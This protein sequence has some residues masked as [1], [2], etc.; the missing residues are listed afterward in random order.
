[1]QRTCIVHSRT[2]A[3]SSPMRTGLINFQPEIHVTQDNAAV[4]NHV[5]IASQYAN[6]A[7]FRKYANRVGINLPPL[8]GCVTLSGCVS[9]CALL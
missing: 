1:M 2:T 8:S 9:A 3:A 7:F 5:V 6:L 4:G